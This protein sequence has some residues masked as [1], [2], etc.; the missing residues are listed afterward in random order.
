[1]Y[2]RLYLENAARQQLQLAAEG[3]HVAMA[4]PSSEAMA[5]AIRD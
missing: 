4:M 3:G 2:Y 1:L 5:A